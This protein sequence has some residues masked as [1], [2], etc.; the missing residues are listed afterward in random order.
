MRVRTP[1]AALLILL[2][3][4]AAIA[5]DGKRAPGR[6]AWMG[7]LLE[8]APV[9]GDGDAA[10]VGGVRLGGII[11]NSPADEAGLRAQDRILAVNGT[12]VMSVRELMKALGRTEPDSWINMSI[13]RNGHE[14]E[15]RLR[16][17][18]RPARV[19]NL[20]VRRGWIGIG[21]IDLPPQL[22]ERFGAPEQGGVMISE[23][24]PLSP[25]EAAGFELGDVVYEVNGEPVR[26]SAE[27][28]SRIGRGGRGN[29][30]EVT[31]ARDGVEIVLEPLVAEEPT[32]LERSQ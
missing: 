28:A 31:L 23:V 27:L 3:A 19:R 18:T 11:R 15:V 2:L 24:E 21:A 30:I 25:A 7:V 12:A 8:D 10:R 13:E 17:T 4:T 32:E 9:G 20:D 16:L 1:V 29:V 6:R 26:S 14:R 22:A 5:Q